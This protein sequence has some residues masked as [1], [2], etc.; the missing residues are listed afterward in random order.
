M[1]AKRICSDWLVCVEGRAFN[2]RVKFAM[3]STQ[4]V[5]SIDATCLLNTSYGINFASRPLFHRGGPQ[6]TWIDLKKN[7]KSAKEFEA[8]SC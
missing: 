6:S 3:A 4:K 1:T 8:L 2:D 5:Q 7:G